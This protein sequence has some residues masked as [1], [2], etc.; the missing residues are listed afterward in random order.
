MCQCIK[1]PSLLLNKKTASATLSFLATPLMVWCLAHPW[2]LIKPRLLRRKGP[3][4][5][6]DA[7]S[8]HCTMPN[9][10]RSQGSLLANSAPPLLLHKGQIHFSPSW[11]PRQPINPASPL[12]TTGQRRLGS[13]TTC[14]TIDKKCLPILTSAKSKI[15]MA[16]QQRHKADKRLGLLNFYLDVMC[17]NIVQDRPSW[18][19]G[20]FPTFPNTS[21]SSPCRGSLKTP[22]SRTI[23]RL[24]C[25]EIAAISQQQDP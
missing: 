16:A 7:P 8:R 14:K 18:A 24:R 3:A 25:G 9:T 1:A 12:A 10:S 15:G 2:L 6:L 13:P 20:S 4:T 19:H 22:R 5:H 23:Q 17:N 11:A 21:S